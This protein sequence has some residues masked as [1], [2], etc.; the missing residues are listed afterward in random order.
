[1]NLKQKLDYHYKLFDKTQISPDPLQ[2]LHLFSK[3]EDIELVGF[4]A[5]I[6]AYGNVKQIINILDKI[7]LISNSK[8]YEFV[9]NF[10]KEGSKIKIRLI[11]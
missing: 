4:I 8:P 5:S 7:L 11:R 2:F 3:E 10:N 1:M 9:I 6:F